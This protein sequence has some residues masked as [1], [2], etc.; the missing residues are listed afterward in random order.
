[1][2][3]NA[4]SF[5]ISSKIRGTPISHE[6][7]RAKQGENLYFHQVRHIA[8]NHFPGY[9]K[10]W[11]CVC[12]ESARERSTSYLLLRLQTDVNFRV[13]ISRESAQCML[14]WR[15]SAINACK[16]KYISLTTHMSAALSVW[17]FS[18]CSFPLL[19]M[20]ELRKE[21]VLYKNMCA[22]SLINKYYSL[23]KRDHRHETQRA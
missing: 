11:L 1:M 14:A 17:Q 2:I 21:G 8:C 6:E 5:I 9:T 20:I 16:L 15:N 18:S 13:D 3:I 12:L 22:F 4:S 19:F 7:K 10:M 23:S